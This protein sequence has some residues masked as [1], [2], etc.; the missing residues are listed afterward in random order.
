MKK[1]IL[2]LGAYLML[3]ATS[4]T[5]ATA[6]EGIA[7]NTATVAS[8]SVESSTS[9]TENEET[10]VDM[11]TY[12]TSLY[13]QIDFEG[14]NVLSLEVFKKAYNGY[15]NLKNAGKLG[16]NNV[17]TICDFNLSS[18]EPRM[19]VIDLSKKK[20]LFNTYVA[21]GQ[22]SGDMFATKFSNKMNSH[23]SSL[24]FYVTSE[25]Y[26]GS[27][28][29]QLRLKGMDEG[30]NDD[31]LD[32]GVVVHGSKYVSEDYAMTNGRCGR[33]WGCPAVAANLARPIINNI[34]GGSCLFIYAND[35]KYNSHAYW[36][37]KKASN[38]PSDAYTASMPKLQDLPAP[39]T[40][41][42]TTPA[43]VTTQQ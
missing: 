38:V 11:D 12:I 30:F 27:H 3:T 29:L 20:V 18:N 6:N 8:T 16:D 19:W 10:K 17:L 7:T 37:N 14:N 32:R 28:G 24:G 39:T 36:M 31:A 4:F 41:D 1:T 2:S 40:P 26:N 22:G 23:Q 25:I 43:P 21:H 33:S 9:P 5:V 13:N 35:E 42:V 34:K 15:L